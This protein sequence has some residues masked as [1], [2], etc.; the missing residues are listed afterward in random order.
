M[1]IEIWFKTLDNKTAF[2]LPRNPAEYTIGYEMD[3][4]TETV[5]SLGEV[6]LPGKRKLRTIGFESYYPKGGDEIG[7]KPALRVKDFMDLVRGW[8]RDSVPIRVI[9]ITMGA[10]FNCVMMIERFQPRMRKGPEDVWYALDL[11]E[12]KDLAPEKLPAKGAGDEKPAKE[13]GGGGGK[14]NTYI[15]KK[16]DTLQKI[17]QKVYGDSSRW[18]EIQKKNGLS[19]YDYYHLKVGQV[20]KV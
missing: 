19:R 6:L 5:H 2:M 18:R 7:L 4:K 17:A 13:T 8:Q 16:G 14:A 9:A 20:L 12:W 1:A 10:S 11:I 15:V 3:H